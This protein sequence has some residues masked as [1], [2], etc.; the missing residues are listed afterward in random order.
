MDVASAADDIWVAPLGS[1]PHG[2]FVWVPLSETDFRLIA[3]LTNGE[4]LLEETRGQ[5]FALA[6]RGG[7]LS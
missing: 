2:A 4:A 1:D 6:R 3:H 5:F 7:Q